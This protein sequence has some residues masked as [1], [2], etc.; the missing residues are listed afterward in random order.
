MSQWFLKISKYSDELLSDLDKLDNWPN[1]V[2]IMQK[3]WIGKSTGVEIDFKIYNNDKN[4]TVFTTRPDTI[5][6][7]TFLALSIEHELIVNLSK[8]MMIL[9]NLLKTVKA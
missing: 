2:K 4:I 3:N 6:G 9:K 7:A 5:Y 8:K 1:K